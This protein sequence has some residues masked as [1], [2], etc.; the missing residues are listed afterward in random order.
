MTSSYDKLVLKGGR[1]FNVYTGELLEQDIFIAQ[2]RIVALLPAGEGNS[3]AFSQV[4]QAFAQ[5]AQVVDVSG[6]VV[7]PG[8]VEPH[9]HIGLLAEPVTTL[10]QMARTGTTTVVADAYPFM[11]TLPDDELERAFDELQR[12]P[13]LLR[14]FLAPHARAF[15]ENEAELFDEARIERLLTRP[16]VVALGELTRWPLVAQGDE[17]MQAKIK[18]AISLGKRVEGHAAG[19]S[20]PRLQR[21]AFYGVTSDHEAITPEQV[22]ERVRLGFYTMLRHSSLRPDLPAL[23]EAL[24]A[25]LAHSN[26]IMLT[27]DGPTP[28]WI[29]KHGYLDH[30]IRLAIDSG[31]DVAAAY[32]MVTINPAMYYRIEDEVGGI[33]P[34]RR[35]DVNVLDDLTN[36]TPRLVMAAGRIIASEGQIVEPFSKVA[37]DRFVGMKRP[38]GVPPQASLFEQNEGSNSVVG[39]NGDVPTLELAHTVLLQRSHPVDGEHKTQGKESEPTA[40]HVAVYDWQGRWVTRAFLKGF[41]EKLGGFATSYNAAGQLTILGQDGADMAMAARQVMAAGGGMCLVEE[42]CVVWEMPLER[43]GL[44]TELRW[45]ALVAALSELEQLMVRRGYRYHELLYSL[46]FFG[47]DSL[48]DFRLTAKG[49]W[50]VRRQRVVAPP[51]SLR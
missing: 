18:H 13:V 8:Y 3:D 27:A 5:D 24:S 22:S 41:A 23:A 50:D 51:L 11:V 44:F 17:D 1:V 34:G 12:L 40:L 14:W 30:L 15:M 28:V 38:E 46:F 26:R 47:F 33:A 48:P 25:A 37:W 2:G 19:A 6:R 16:D 29:E 4:T 42:G 43:A 39:G 31:I 35:A 20:P 36:P 32:R 21:L 7:V 10:E 45:D 49:V 9:A